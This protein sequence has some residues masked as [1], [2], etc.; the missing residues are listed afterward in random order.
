LE[1]SGVVERRPRDGARIAALDLEGVIKLVE[2]LAE[3]EGTIAFLAAR[4]INPG[5]AANLKRAAQ[6]CTD[7]AE[8]RGPQGLN[9]YDLNLDFQTCL[10]AASGNEHMEQAV[11]LVA[12]R[13]VAY[14][15]AR[16]ALPNELQRSAKD[17]EEITQ[18][19][20]NG[21]A[22]LARSL[23]V[24]HIIFSDRLAI[25]VMNAMRTEKE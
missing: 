14:L 16:H 24:D 25:D 18:A 8:G 3:T 13:L 15:A 1:T 10:F 21:E 4:R 7:F 11:R 23:M 22:E 17:H 9:Y 12:N 20:L 5:Q 2:V 6:A 19:I